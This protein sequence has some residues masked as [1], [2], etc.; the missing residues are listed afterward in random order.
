MR[1]L[2]PTY[3]DAVDLHAAYAY[4]DRRPW[5][6]ANM[7]SSADGAVTLEGRSGG[8]SG[9]ADREIF[10]LLRSLSDVIL[11]GAGTVRAEH[12]GPAEP[13]SAHAEPS[14][15]HAEERAGRGAPP[16]PVIAVVSQRL[17]LD[18]A[19]PLFAKA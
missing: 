2:L 5:V 14:S 12:Y 13:S 3:A 9:A 17:E 16:A 6:R 1:R 8:L 11:V 15:E 18:P 19:A 7:V 10:A 4:P